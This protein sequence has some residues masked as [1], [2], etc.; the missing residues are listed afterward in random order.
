MPVALA[1]EG[2]GASF[3]VALDVKQPEVTYARAG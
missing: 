1:E 3:D 2:Y